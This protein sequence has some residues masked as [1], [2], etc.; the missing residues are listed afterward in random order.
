MGCHL[1]TIQMSRLLKVKSDTITI[2]EYSQI[3]MS[4]AKF[5]GMESPIVIYTHKKAMAL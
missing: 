5:N 2:Y 4:T 1:Y 3:Q